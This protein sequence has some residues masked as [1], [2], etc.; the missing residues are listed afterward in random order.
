[1]VGNENGRRS[2]RRMRMR[3]TNFLLLR[4][5]FIYHITMLAKIENRHC[6]SFSDHTIYD[7]RFNSSSTHLSDRALRYSQLFSAGF[8][9]ASSLP[10]SCISIS[11][12]TIN[13]GRRRELDRMGMRMGMRTTNFLLSSY[14]IILNS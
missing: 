12:F 14:K 1:M 13:F 9:F 4:N 8:C 2:R 7:L 3:T 5:Q 10:F 11:I 6:D